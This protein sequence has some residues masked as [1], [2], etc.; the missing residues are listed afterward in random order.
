MCKVSCSKGVRFCPLS[1][2]LYNTALYIWLCSFIAT[3]LLSVK[4]LHIDTCGLLPMMTTE[5]AR[6][7]TR[8]PKAG[9]S[10]SYVTEAPP[11]F[12]ESYNVILSSTTEMVANYMFREEKQAFL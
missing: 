12:T 6:S 10:Q 9:L 3:Y 11:K 2:R 5:E 1:S 8:A 4:L 7:S